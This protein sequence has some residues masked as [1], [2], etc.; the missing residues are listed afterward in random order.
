MSK[1]E[2]SKRDSKAILDSSSK[3]RTGASRSDTGKKP[4]IKKRVSKKRPIKKELFGLL[5]KPMSQGYGVGM[6]FLLQFLELLL[7]L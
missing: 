6:F 3:K 1:R 7:G 2:M 4:S 5:K